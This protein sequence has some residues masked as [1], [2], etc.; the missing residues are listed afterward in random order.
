MALK[1]I[2]RR[3]H[4]VAC[5]TAILSSGVFTSG[6]YDRQELES[7]AFVT[8]I[9]VDK[10][11]DGQIDCTMRLALPKNPS[12]GGGGGGGGQPLAGSGPVTYR[13]R[14][15]TEAMLLAN[16]NIERQVSMSHLTMIFFGEDLAKQGLKDQLQPLVRFRDFRRTT[17]VALAKGKAQEVMKEEKPMIDQSA[18]RL[19]DSIAEV[20]TRTGLFPTVHLHDFLSALETHHESPLL[21]VFAVNEAVQKDPKGEKGIQSE[22][23]DYQ[24]GQASR[25]GG[26]PVEWMGA[27]VFRKDKLVG[28]LN[29]RESIYLRMLKGTLRTVKLDFP[30]ENA[31]NATVSVFVR[32]EHNPQYVVSLSNPV[33]I[34]VNVPL[35]ADLISSRLDYRTAPMRQKLEQQLKGRLSQEL[36]GLLE[37]LLHEKGADVIPISESIRRKFRTDA[38][39]ANYP[40]ETMMKTADI[41]VNVDL[42]IRRFGVQMVPIGLT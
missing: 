29:G 33:K 32:K 10:A 31:K 36:K 38:E 23:A 1:E 37:N 26:N 9:G 19:S 3:T 2:V 12:S 27:A 11:P 18:G 24:P 17:L 7:Q 39:F 16:S 34:Q 20:G 4:V 42:R 13:G 35:D 41:D 25:S 21:P 28:Y 8:T 40:W 14:S 15:V 22:A 30:D 5:M 6:C